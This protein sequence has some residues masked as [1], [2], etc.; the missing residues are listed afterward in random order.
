[1]DMNAKLQT[2]I[3]NVF[4]PLASLGLLA[5]AGQAAALDVTVIHGINGTDLGLDE[6]LPVDIS[7]N[8]NCIAEGVTFR[9]QANVADLIGQNLEPGQ[10]TIEIHLSDANSFDGCTGALAVTSQVPLQLAENT[11]LIAHLSEAGTPTLSKFVNNVQPIEHGKAR[12]SVRHTAA[13]P[14]V[15]LVGFPD[16]AR[17]ATLFLDLTNG[18]GK[19]ADIPSGNTN[20]YLRDNQTG[21]APRGAARRQALLTPIIPVTIA[22]EKAIAAY[23]V[24]SAKNG[25]L[26]LIVQEL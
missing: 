4:S 26:E 25:S 13:A 10:Y 11:T 24:G 18:S 19:T 1:M 8:G 7:A 3:K 5:F 15:K 14:H 16:R 20:V 6:A 12:L 17:Y 9:T 22:D 23:A 2:A 21:I